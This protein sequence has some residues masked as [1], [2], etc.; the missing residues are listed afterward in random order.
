MVLP[1][2]SVDEILMCDDP[3]SNSNEG[4]TKLYFSFLLVFS[5]KMFVT[6][7]PVDADTVCGDVLRVLFYP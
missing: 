6:F 3:N 2:E 4:F 5:V 1:F 7:E